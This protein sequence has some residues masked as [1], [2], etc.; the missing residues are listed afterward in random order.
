MFIQEFPG[1]GNNWRNGSHNFTGTHDSC[2]I[3]WASGW[4]TNTATPRLG[5]LHKNCPC[6]DCWFTCPLFGNAHHTIGFIMCPHQKMKLL[7]ISW[8]NLLAQMDIY[9]APGNRANLN[10]MS[11]HTL[12]TVMHATTY[13]DVFQRL[14]DNLV[15]IRQTVKL[16]CLQVQEHMMAILNAVS[17]GM[18][19]QSSTCDRYNTEVSI[20]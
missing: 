6:P 16:H 5:K 17:I 9:L 11:W 20:G 10:I 8:Q 3:K 18:R 1:S 2:G 7:A 19:F 4:H 12:L 13:C 14:I 15:V